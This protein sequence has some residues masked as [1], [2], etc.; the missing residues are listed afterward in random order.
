M[1]VPLPRAGMRGLPGAQGARL[2]SR[3]QIMGASGAHKLQQAQ[4]EQVKP[5]HL[6]PVQALRLLQQALAVMAA[7]G[8][9]VGLALF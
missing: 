4:R 5:A 7:L 8:G 3:A 2:P 6:S 1:G 9:G